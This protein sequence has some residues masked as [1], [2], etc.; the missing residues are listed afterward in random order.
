MKI[1][2]VKVFELE[3]PPRSGLA[4]YE[5]ERGGLAPNQA[6]PYRHT[7]TEIETDQGITG[8]SYGGSAE[9]K[10]LGQRLIGQDPLAVE[11]IWEQLYTRAYYRGQHLNS[12]SILDLALWDLIGKAKSEP[13]YRLLGGPCRE[14]IR[15]YAAL[16]GF[17]TDPAA[18]AERSL[19]W[20]EKG[21]TG[22]KWYL[23]YNETAGEE[24]LA[25]NAALVKAV[26][27]AVGDQV[28]IMVDCIL[29]NSSGNSLLYALKLAHRLE[30]YRLTWLEEPLNPEDLEAYQKLARATTI[31]LAFGERMHT[32]WQFK[33]ALETGAATVLQPELHGTGGLTEMRK[34][35]ALL[36]TYGVP[37]VPHANETCRNA[38]HLLFAMPQR[39]CPLAEWG[40]KINHN[41]QF[42]YQDFYEPVNG[43]FELPHGPGFGYELDPDKIVRR[44]DF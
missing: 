44:T 16:L 38:I 42:F 11:H 37:L 18:A 5:T 43:Y 7:F 34:I 26:R 30:P 1:T 19:E 13:V 2:N 8:L 12:L 25:H 40:I 36:S 32:R 35:A 6:T 22:L 10:T 33:Q 21:F 28:D 17:S 23:P 15:A 41:V 3:G 14:R 9:V 4:L 20:V 31:P 27:E 24:G 39:I 29:S